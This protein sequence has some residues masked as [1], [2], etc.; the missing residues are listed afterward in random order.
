MSRTRTASRRAIRASAVA[1]VLA[2]ALTP[3][4]AAGPADPPVVTPGQGV[5]PGQNQVAP[6]GRP[7]PT[8][9]DPRNTIPEKVDPPASQGVSPGT[10]GR[11]SLSEKLERGDGVLAP[12]MTGAPDMRV[13]AP[14]PNPNTT[15]VIPPPGEPGNPS[16]VQP[17]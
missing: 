11:E 8:P 4:L 16:P 1:V 10:Q 15:P 9:G 12:P 13:P 2:W 7:V 14:T 5:A 17:K 3:A 6:G